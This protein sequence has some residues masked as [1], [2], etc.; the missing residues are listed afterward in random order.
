MRFEWD[1]HKAWANF[2]KHGVSFNEAMEV[3]YDPNA[4]ERYDD[5]HSDDESRFTIIGMSSR[6]L[7]HVA[8]TERAGETLRL[9]SARKATGTER[10]LYERRMVQ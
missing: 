3:F 9:I 1:A 4:L 6:R 10:E 2:R 5:L 7:L 8:Y